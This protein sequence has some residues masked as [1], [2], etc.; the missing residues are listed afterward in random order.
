MLLL[1]NVSGI[2]SRGMRDMFRAVIEAVFAAGYVVQAWA[3]LCVYNVGGGMAWLL[4]AGS[5]LLQIGLGQSFK[6]CVRL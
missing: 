4:A 1:E 2:R 5:L 3:T 6:A